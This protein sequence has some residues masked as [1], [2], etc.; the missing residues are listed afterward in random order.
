MGEEDF[1]SASTTITQTTLV[2]SRE[3]ARRLST[4][5]RHIHH[6]VRSGQLPVVLIGGKRRFLIG[7][8][9]AFVDRSRRAPDSGPVAA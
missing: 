9:A 7:D 2:T 1:M 6:L 3:A 4:S 8:L 5:D